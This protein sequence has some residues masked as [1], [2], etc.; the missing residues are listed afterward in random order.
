VSALPAFADTS[1]SATTAAQI[2]IVL[3]G[4]GVVGGALLKLLD[5]P[6]AT[7]VRLVGV[8]NSRQQL[9]DLAGLA[10]LADACVRAPQPDGGA[11]RDDGR[12]LAALD[13][14]SAPVKLIVDATACSALAAQHV[15]WLARGYHVVTAN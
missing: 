7:H 13:A 2:A 9:T 15:T 14:S 6:A 3:L 12:L 11:P 5:T 1:T 8:A 10:G 4:T